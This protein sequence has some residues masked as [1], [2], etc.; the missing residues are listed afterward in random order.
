[1][2]LPQLLPQRLQL[3]LCPDPLSPLLLQLGAHVLLGLLD[4]DLGS[5]LVI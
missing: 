3:L 5:L 2:L 1:M 4:T